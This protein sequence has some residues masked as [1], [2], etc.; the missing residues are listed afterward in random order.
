MRYSIFYKQLLNFFNFFN[1]SSR[2]CYGYLQRGFGSNVAIVR[3]RCQTSRE[4]A[5]LKLEY[6]CSLLCKPLYFHSDFTAVYYID[7]V[8]K[9][10]HTVVLWRRAAVGKHLPVECGMVKYTWCKQNQSFSPRVHFILPKSMLSIPFYNQIQ[11][12]T[13]CG[14]RAGI[15]L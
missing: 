6:I 2:M 15:K 4:T 9:Y 7:L 11:Q 5:P 10:L 8:G 12:G 1:Y 14:F 13:S 3:L